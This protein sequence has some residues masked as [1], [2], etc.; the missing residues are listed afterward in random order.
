MLSHDELERIRQEREAFETWRR[1]SRH[2]VADLLEMCAICGTI[3]DKALLTRCLWCKDTYVCRDRNC[4]QRHRVR[5]HSAV[6]F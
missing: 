4:A 2:V 5:L 3:R 1:Y 6:A